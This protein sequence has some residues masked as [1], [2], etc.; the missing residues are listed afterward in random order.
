[1]IDHPDFAWIT[2]SSVLI[3]I[4]SG[5]DDIPERFN[6]YDLLHV[7]GIEPVNGKKGNKRRKSS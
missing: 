1:V 3:G 2:R 4:S 5:E 7:V 6:Q